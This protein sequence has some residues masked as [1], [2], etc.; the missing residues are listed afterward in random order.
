MPFS[1]DAP[2]GRDVLYHAYVENW[3]SVYDG[4]YR[5]LAYA[6]HDEKSGAIV[7]RNLLFDMCEDPMEAN[8]LSTD[9]EQVS[10]MER[11]ESLLFDQRDRYSDP[12]VSEG[13][14]DKYG[15]EKPTKPQ[16]ATR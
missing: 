6:G 1:G 8:D 9:P 2:S 3:R 14:W 13:F 4:R 16:S 12:V 10:N 11:L 7:R 15:S 5:F